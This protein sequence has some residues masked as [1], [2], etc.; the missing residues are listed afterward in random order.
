VQLTRQ[1]FGDEVRAF[2]QH[3]TWDSGYAQER[4]SAEATGA[5]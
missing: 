4:R 5:A 1:A 3:Q 2:I